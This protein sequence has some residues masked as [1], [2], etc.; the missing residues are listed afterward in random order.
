MPGDGPICNSERIV[1]VGEAPGS[2][3]NKRGRCFV[4]G[5]GQEFDQGYLPLTGLSRSD[6]Y[7]TNAMK[8]LPVGNGKLQMNNLK[9][10]AI[11]RAC[12]EFHLKRELEIAKP[13]TVVLMGAVPNSLVDGIDLD[14]HYAIPFVKNLLGTERVIFPNWHPAGGLYDHKKMLPIRTGFKRLGQYLKGTLVVHEDEFPNPDYKVAR[15]RADIRELNPEEPLAIDTETRRRGGPHCLTYSDTPGKGR[16]IYVE[17]ESMLMYFAEVVANWKGPIILHNA[18]FDLWVLEQMGIY[19]RH[20]KIID[21]M[22]RAFHLQNQPQG[23]KVLSYRHKGM[24]MQDFDDL[25][26]PHSAQQVIEYY[27]QMLLTPW[28]KP[29]EQLVRDPKTGNLKLY[30]PHSLSTK[31]K[32]FFTSY[33]KNPYK[34]VFEMWT[35]NWEDHHQE[36]E[37]VCGPWPGKCITHAPADKV[38]FYACRDADAT[39]R[40]W[41]LFKVAATRIRRR[42]EIEWMEAA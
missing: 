13:D 9:D 40:L 37:Q 19:I 26:S 25:V 15:S 3:E 10:R 17:D 4:G 22:M 8:C 24:E 36:V 34:D 5:T 31:L 18:L 12:A 27:S 1:F 42:P 7:V 28:P 14:T 38:L 2:E 20:K 41:P 6:V 35:K 30:R 11:V 23:L 21:T 32:I 33:G 39:R 16:L 29:E